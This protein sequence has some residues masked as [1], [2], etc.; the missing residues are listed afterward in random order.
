LANG[1]YH[2]SVDGH[3]LRVGLPV[4]YTGESSDPDDPDG[5]L[6]HGHPG[7]VADPRPEDVFVEWHGLEDRPVSRW[8]SFDLPGLAELTEDEYERRVGRLADGQPPLG[9]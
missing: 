2:R 7:R 8:L 9:E 4:E 5:W 1:A 3:R 6:R